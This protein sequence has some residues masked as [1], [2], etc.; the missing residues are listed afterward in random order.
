MTRLEA[1]FA[2]DAAELVAMR[3][4]PKDEEFRELVKFCVGGKID[5]AR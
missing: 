4:S 2:G 1:I 5:C 3:I